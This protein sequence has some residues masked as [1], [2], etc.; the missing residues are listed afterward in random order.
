[1]VRCRFGYTLPTKQGS[2]TM[3]MRRLNGDFVFLSCSAARLRL[4]SRAIGTKRPAGSGALLDSFNPY[5]RKVGASE[6]DGGAVVAISIGTTLLS[7]AAEASVYF[8]G[9]LKNLGRGF[10]SAESYRLVFRLVNALSFAASAF[11]LFVLGIVSQVLEHRLSNTIEP[12]H[13]P[14]GRSS[15]P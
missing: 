6:P 14:H 3:P 13:T 5:V 9:R 10:L 11:N 15:S 2:T 7:G 4:N 12:S 1:M 8:I